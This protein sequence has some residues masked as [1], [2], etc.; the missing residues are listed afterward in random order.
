MKH[1]FRVPDMSCAH[2]AKAIED[3]L[4]DIGVG[5][6]TFDLDDHAVVVDTEQD[7]ELVESAMRSAGY[8]P[9]PV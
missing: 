6:V 9:I 3:A 5:S 7:V 4:R 1:R 2:C 8:T